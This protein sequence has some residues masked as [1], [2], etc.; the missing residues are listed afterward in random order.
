MSSQHPGKAENAIASP[1]WA[2][3]RAKAA[4]KVSKIPVPRSD[5]KSIGSV[6]GYARIGRTSCLTLQMTAA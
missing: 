1:A 5:G 6:S 4:P 2:A 3:V